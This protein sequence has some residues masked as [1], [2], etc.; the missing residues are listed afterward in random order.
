MSTGNITPEFIEKW[1]IHQIMNPVGNNMM[2]MLWTVLEAAGESKAS[3]AKPKSPKSKNRSTAL[4]IIMAQIHFLCSR[5]S[6]KVPIGLGLQS[7]ACGTSRQMIDVLH[8]TCLTVSYAS[9]SA[10]VQSLADRSIE[11]V[12]A[13]SLHPHALAYDN[14]NISSSIFVEQGP[15]AMSKVQSGTFAVVY[16]LLNA[17]AEDMDIGPLVE[18]LRQSSPLDISSLRM[19][20]QAAASY[21]SQ[22][23]ISILRI[24]SKYVN[25]FEVQLT[26]A[27]LQCPQR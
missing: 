13:A 5:N 14:I 19:T 16:E 12:K 7:W 6:A 26:D 25:G 9:I 21:V 1:D 20:P 2:P 11:Q 22:T 15:N 3:S 18:N 4:L 8:R 24:L 10:M 27:Y 23:A 17:R